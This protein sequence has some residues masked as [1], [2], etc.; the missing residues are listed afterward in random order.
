MGSPWALA[1]SARCS[2]LLRAADG[3]V[4]EARSHY[5]RSL[6]LLDAHPY[7]LERARTLLC[8]GSARRQDKQKRPAREAIEQALEIFEKLG[9]CPWA[10]R[11]RAELR[12]ISGRQPSSDDL[13]ATERRVAALAAQGRTNKEIAAELFM[14]LS[15]VE[16]HLSR[17]YRKLGVRSRTE[18]ARQ[19]AVDGDPHGAT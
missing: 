2:G 8:L 5:E 3:D 12:R 11:A 7:P 4:A 1:V 6:T 17:V 18:L 16:S 9:A 19:L 15:T 14:G 10:E 13:T